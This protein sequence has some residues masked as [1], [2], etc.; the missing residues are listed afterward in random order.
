MTIPSDFKAELDRI[1]ALFAQTERELN[2]LTIKA[3]FEVDLPGLQHTMAFGRL[4]GRFRI[5]YGD[6][7][8]SDLTAV[9]KIAVAEH[10]YEF[11]DAY[12]NYLTE[13]AAR[14]R[15]AGKP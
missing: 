7:P 11:K 6:R 13:L 5:W 14:A 12:T 8:I 15:K 3:D 10:L 1:C 2:D 9:E 4:K